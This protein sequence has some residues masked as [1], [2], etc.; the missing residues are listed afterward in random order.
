[1]ARP[2]AGRPGQN[3]FHSEAANCIIYPAVSSEEGIACGV[4]NR[5]MTNF[6]SHACRNQIF[7]SMLPNQ[8]CDQLLYLNDTTT[9]PPHSCTT[10]SGPCA[11]FPE[12]FFSRG[13]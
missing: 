7:R 9:M 5:L 10:G 6:F 11:P 12:K 1:M 13:L 2:V 3:L 8:V 4:S